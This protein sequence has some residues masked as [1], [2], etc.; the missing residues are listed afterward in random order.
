MPRVSILLTCYNH[1]TYLPE[2]LEGVLSQTFADYEILAL[3]DGSTDGTREWL[4]EKEAAGLL[5]CIFNEKNIGTYGTLNV[6]LAEAA[7]DLIA[8]LNDDDLWAPE[9]L[10]RQVALFNEN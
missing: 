1:L 7:G 5:R 8:V 6:G 3:D 10:A 2:C 4:L 9:K